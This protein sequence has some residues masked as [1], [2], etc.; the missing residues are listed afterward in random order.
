MPIA[1][2]Q[3]YTVTGTIYSNKSKA[4]V[5]DAIVQ[6]G[7][8]DGSR[9]SEDNIF[10]NANF[11]PVGKCTRETKDDGTFKINDVQLI[12]L[13]NP[14]ER[15]VVKVT[16]NDGVFY[17]KTIYPKFDKYTVS[18]P[19]GKVCI[20]DSLADKTKKVVSEVTSKVTDMVHKIIN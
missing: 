16:V 20:P 4:P 7:I 8:Y 3:Y 19:L 11:R 2:A 18:I 5:K 9:D 6:L 10:V 14:K 1:D 17:H 13:L 12:P 15:Y